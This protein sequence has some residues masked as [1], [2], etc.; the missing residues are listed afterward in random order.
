MDTQTRELKL[1]LQNMKCFVGRNNYP[2]LNYALISG[3]KM[4]VSDGV[5]YLAYVG[6]WNQ[7][8]HEFLIPIKQALD[9]I[10]SLPKDSMVT[11]TKTGIESDGVSVSWEPM[12]VTDYP[13]IPE[14]PRMT[15]SSFS[16]LPE[17]ISQVCYASSIDT[18]RFQLDNVC[19]RWKDGTLDVVATDGHRLS[20]QSIPM[21]QWISEK[22]I[23]I[24][25][26]ICEVMKHT[27]MDYG[28]FKVHN[29][30]LFVMD[31]KWIFIVS[32][33][34]LSQYVS[35]EKF[36]SFG[37]PE[38]VIKVD[39]KQFIQSLKTIKPATNKDHRG[40]TIRSN[41]S[42]HI[43]R[44]T[45]KTTIPYQGMEGLDVILNVDYLLETLSNLTD[46]DVVIRTQPNNGPVT[47][48]SNLYKTNLI[49]PLRK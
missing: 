9:I 36:V 13:R 38:H 11:I 39:R 20:L 12:D 49:M 32:Q 24:P 10:S 26:R 35:Y 27:K 40:V 43:S 28:H 37:S 47:F 41:E 23:L 19:L 44:D 1:A 16:H 4:V 29:D 3:N 6:T 7:V 2:I 33:K 15:G 22:D 34:S 8:D 25:E 31:E 30:Y 42:L 46:R 17:V 14:I 21:D 45:A 18:Y 48:D 5:N